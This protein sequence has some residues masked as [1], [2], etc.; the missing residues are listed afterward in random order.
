MQM[1][2]DLDDFLEYVKNELGEETWIPLYKNLDKEN[3][4]EDGALY[5]TLVAF[6]DLPK[7]MSEYGWDIHQGCGG[8]SIVTC[9][10]R[11]WYELHASNYRPLVICRYFTGV[12]KSYR[13][14]SQELILFHNLFHDAVNSKYVVDDDNGLEIIVIKYTDDKILIQRSF[15]EAFMAAKQMNLLLYFE[16]TRHKTE[17]DRHSE[18]LKAVK[19]ITYRRFWGDSYVRGFNT[20]TRVLGKK[21]FHC[22]ELT[23]KNISPFKLEKEY[24]DFIIKG[25]S[26]AN[27]T[28]TCNPDFLANSFGK[29]KTSLNYL[30]PVYFRKE[31]LQKYFGSPKE[32][33]VQDSRLTKTGF[34]TLRMDNNATDY[35]SVFLGDL[36]NDI[37]HSEQ[38]YWKSFNISPEDKN[39]S[40]TY[41]KRNILGLFSDPKNPGLVFKSTFIHFQE[42]WFNKYGWHLFLPLAEADSH[43]FSTLRSLI[44]EE[45]VEFDSQVLALVKVTIDSINAKQLKMLTTSDEIGSSKLLSNYLGDSEITF[46]ASE[47]LGGLQGIRSTGVA[48]RKGS[49][50]EST[51]AKLKIDDSDFTGAFDDMLIKMSTLLNEISEKLIEENSDCEDIDKT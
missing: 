4:E 39:I 22:T 41:F 42:N 46:N 23:E 9:G 27:T 3:E 36:G 24:E 31:V 18:E 40:R 14:I 49:K 43:C 25:D 16:L 45:Q 33:D 11:I 30:T 26:H 28:H 29:N 34:W 12:R 50:Y 17:N 8:P 32:Y 48:H 15:L 47:F 35:I 37:P 7:A 51:I 19:S 6:S 38:I 21:L 2:K 44:K 1:N 20:F 13:E 5:S 10:D